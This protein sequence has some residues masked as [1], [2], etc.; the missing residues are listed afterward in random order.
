MVGYD[1]TAMC[2]VLTRSILRSGCA[3]MTRESAG[4]RQATITTSGR[5]Q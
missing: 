4:I 3:G 1:E 5:E 2:S